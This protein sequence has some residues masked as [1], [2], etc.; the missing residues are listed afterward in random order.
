VESAWIARADPEF[1]WRRG[2]KGG[3]Y[4]ISGST[5]NKG[6]NMKMRTAIRVSFILLA[7]LTALA[8]IAAGADYK[9]VATW[10]LGGDGGWDYLT[11]DS[12]GHRLFIARA[13]RVMVIDTESGKQVA[14]FR[15]RR[16]SM[17]SR[18]T[19]RSGAD[20]PATAVKIRSACS[21]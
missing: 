18:W 19:L 6:K 3:F 16:A 17:E 9:V 21:I 12:D 1:D 20:S 7:T 15:R 2:P 14:R 10:K 13:T 11:A 4:A 8:S 5:F